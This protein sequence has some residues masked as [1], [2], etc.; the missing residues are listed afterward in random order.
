MT[1]VHLCGLAGSISVGDNSVTESVSESRGVQS[2]T[3][4]YWWSIG[5]ALAD[6][7]ALINKQH[8]QIAVV[9]GLI[10]VGFTAWSLRAVFAGLEH[11][12][13][14]KVLSG[15]QKCWWGKYQT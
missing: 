8:I 13:I 3:V 14:L 7:A 5:G 11:I 10:G 15:D 1:L 2:N 4:A 6:I 12:V 9:I